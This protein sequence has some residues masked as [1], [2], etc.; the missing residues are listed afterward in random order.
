MNLFWDSSAIL[1][2]VFRESKSPQAVQA[3]DA[4]EYA[5]A[6]HWLKIETASALARRSANPGQWTHLQKMLGM[7]RFL[8]LPEADYDDLCATNRRWRLTAADAGHLFCFQQA[9]F[10]LPDLQMVCF[11][12]EMT[13]VARKEG[14]LLWTPPEEGSGTPALVRETRSSYGR[15]RKRAAHV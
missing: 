12:E 4:G 11:D 3:W 9:S 6:W 13:S 15:K 1:S 5:Y 7:F 14:F 2:V 10:V 8:E